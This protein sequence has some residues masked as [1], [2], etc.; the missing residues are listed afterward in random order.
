VYGDASSALVP[1]LLKN[2]D[3]FIPAIPSN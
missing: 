1:F 3:G 2:I